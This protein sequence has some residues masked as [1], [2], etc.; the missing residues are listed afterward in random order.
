MNPLEALET[1]INGNI[2][3]FKEWLKRAKKVDL[4][5]LLEESN[6][7]MGEVDKA[8]LQRNIRKYLS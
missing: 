7:L 3:D 6:V 2:T 8:D 5:D 4:M 1:Y